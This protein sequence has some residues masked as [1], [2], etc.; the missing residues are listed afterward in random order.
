MS[1]GFLL[2]RVTFTIEKDNRGLIL[3]N[4]GNMLHN[5]IEKCNSKSNVTNRDEYSSETWMSF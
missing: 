1:C 4:D 5:F 3:F 2:D